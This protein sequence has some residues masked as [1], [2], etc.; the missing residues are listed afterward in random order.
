M[1]LALTNAGWFM[2]FLLVGIVNTKVSLIIHKC[3]NLKSIHGP[4]KNDRSFY[5]AFEYVRLIQNGLMKLVWFKLWLLLPSDGA[6]KQV[7]PVPLLRDA[8]SCV[9]WRQI[10]ACVSPTSAISAQPHRHAS[11]H[12][13]ILIRL[14]PWY[15]KL[16]K[17]P[18]THTLTGSHTVQSYQR[19]LASDPQFI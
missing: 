7:L 2:V 10:L 6:H 1:L 8:L 19:P 15:Q 17:S 3:Q 16:I 11:T 12:G 18:A 13:P 9:A 4:I 14:L 5:Q